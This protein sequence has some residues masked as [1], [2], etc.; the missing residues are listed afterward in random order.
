MAEVT[1]TPRRRRLL[2]RLRRPE[3][4]TFGGLLV[5]LAI[6]VFIASYHLEHLQY[7]TQKAARNMVEQESELTVARDALLRSSAVPA[8]LQAMLRAPPDAEAWSAAVE[9]RA[10][11]LDPLIIEGLR[12]YGAVCR[13]AEG[14]RSECRDAVARCKAF[15]S[16]I[17]RPLSWMGR[18][19][20]DT[21]SAALE[22]DGSGAS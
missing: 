19:C 6:V 17:G 2:A 16:G 12:D 10:D 15:V 9:S 7:R 4:G 20:P 11:R 14:T 8:D 22:P 1:G 13:R 3:G 21:C 18:D 5:T